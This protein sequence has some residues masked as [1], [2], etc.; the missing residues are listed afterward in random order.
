MCI[1]IYIFIRDVSVCVCMCGSDCACVFFLTT[2]GCCFCC[3]WCYSLSLSLS[4]LSLAV[5]RSLFRSRLSLS[6]YIS[7]RVS[8]LSRAIS[9]C[10]GFCFAH[11]LFL[12]SFLLVNQFAICFLLLMTLSQLFFLAIFAASSSFVFAS[13]ACTCKCQKIIHT[14][15]WQQQM[16]ITHTVCVP[17]KR[18]YCAP[19][20]TVCCFCYFFFCPF[21][22]PFVVCRFVRLPLYL[23]FSQ[24]NIANFVDLFLFN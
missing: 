11:H 9:Y 17:A 15:R 16:E 19:F 5:C 1:C 2:F 8:Q 18:T 6:V 7:Y 23:S 10:F 22:R 13:A 21:V 4:L 3:Y 24:A 12:T 20:T 14:H